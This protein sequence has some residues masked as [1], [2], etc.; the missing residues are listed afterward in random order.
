MTDK[1]NEL[2]EMARQ[3]FGK[4][5]PA[6]SKL[7]K[8]VADGQF[9]D[10]QVGD[11]EKDDPAQ[12]DK[13]GKL[14]TLRADRIAWLCSDDHACR[15]VGHKGILIIGAKIEGELDLLFARC[16]FPITFFYCRVVAPMDFKHSKV[17]GLFFD[18]SHIAGLG[19]DGLTA[20]ADINLRE[21]FHTDGEVCLVGASIGGNLDCSKGRFQNQEGDALSADGL[22]VEGDVNLRD[23]FHSKGE[24]RLLGASIGGDL[25]CSK[26]LFHNPKGRALSADH[27]KVKGSVNLRDGFHSKGEVRLLG[28]GIGGSLYCSKGHFQNPDGNALCAD[29]LKVE[30]DVNLGEGFHAEGEVRLLGASIGGNLDCAGG[31][32]QNPEGDALSAEMAEIDGCVFLREGLDNE[33]KTLKPVIRGRVS[34]IR[35]D[36]KGGFQWLDITTPDDVIL[37]LEHANFGV[38]VDEPTCWPKADNLYL[39]GFTYERIDGLQ[40]GDAKSRIEWIKRSQPGHFTP[41]P[42]EQLAKVF[43][44]TGLDHEARNV[45]IAKNK[46]YRRLITLSTMQKVWYHLLGPLIG[47]GYRPW[48]MIYWAVVIFAMGTLIFWGGERAR[49]FSPAQ[50]WAYADSSS[51]VYSIA[52]ADSHLAVVGGSLQPALTARGDTLD[53][54]LLRLDYPRLQLLVYS[55]D[56]FVPLVDLHQ[57]R[58]WLP[59]LKKIPMID[60]DL[61]PFWRVMGIIAP[62]YLWV[63]ILLGWFV[64][65]LLLVGLTGIIRT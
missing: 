12:G 8:E 19:A 17:G 15:F 47:F 33:G 2:L 62:V 64:T 61:H 48:N 18:G 5:I 27:L 21:G 14:R 31:R 28:A 16:T 11:K 20:Y 3:R 41:Q 59:N 51:A 24:V 53:G 1:A 7:F 56:A 39:D 29:G 45:L 4:L 42:Y 26:G 63:H 6:E 60:P 34:F 65:T 37:D 38:L 32:F 46:Q 25:N 13:W 43:N 58:Y 35:A 50:Y 23:G 40:S 9:A 30:G 54:R 36:L 10:Y 44:D 55:L 22:K 49:V 57:V 52:G